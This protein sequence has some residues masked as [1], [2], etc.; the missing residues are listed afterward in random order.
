VGAE[1][2]AEG[3]LRWLSTDHV[4]LYYQHRMDRNKLIEDIVGAQSEPVAEGEV[5]AD[6]VEAVER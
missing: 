4:D 2:S 3:S 1:P 5:V 6:E